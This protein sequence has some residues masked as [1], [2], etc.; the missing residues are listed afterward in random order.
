MIVGDPFVAAVKQQVKG[1]TGFNINYPANADS[2]SSNKGAQMVAEHLTSQPKA[3]PNQMFVVTGYSQ[4]A[5]VLR[6]AMPKIP[7][8]TQRKII[9]IVTFGDPG[10]KAGGKTGAIRGGVGNSGGGKYG[11]LPTL[12]QE[13]FFTNC[14][15]GDPTCGGG[16]NIL[17]HLTYS[18]GEYMKKSAAFVRSQYYKLGGK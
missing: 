15:S 1:A 13:R 7:E 9:A 4:G 3:C 6:K 18:K 5:S 8:S 2:N 11:A 14:A 17:A 10:Y 12:L 16:S